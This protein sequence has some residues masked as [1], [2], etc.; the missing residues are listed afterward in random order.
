M[1]VN[2]KFKE[3]VVS[4]ILL[5]KQTLVFQIS[6]VVALSSPKRVD[7]HYSILEQ[8][9]TYSSLKTKESMDLFTWCLS[10]EKSKERF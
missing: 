9:H 1:F 8:E 7:L 10:S 6:L 5:S 2:I 3:K 4:E